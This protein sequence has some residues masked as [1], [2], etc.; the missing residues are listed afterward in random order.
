M[1][2]LIPV[3][4]Q[5]LENRGILWL[6]MNQNTNVFRAFTRRQGSLLISVGGK[7]LLERTYQKFPYPGVYSFIFHHKITPGGRK[8]VWWAPVSS[9]WHEPF[10]YSWSGQEEGKLEKGN[11]NQFMCLWLLLSSLILL[12]MKCIIQVKGEGWAWRGDETTLWWWG[13]GGETKA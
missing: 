6:F 7:V 13:G 4:V 5:V 2:L 3:Q 9:S 10:G 11:Y 8:L 12:F 1:Y